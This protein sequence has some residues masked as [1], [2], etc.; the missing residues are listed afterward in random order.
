MKSASVTIKSSTMLM[1]LLALWTIVL[2]LAGCGT[3]QQASVSSACQV[4][5]DNLLGVE[6]T[7]QDGNRRL[8]V[9]YERGISASCWVRP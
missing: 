6:A 9:H 4:F 1:K 2:M 3:A 5:R 8:A 7:T